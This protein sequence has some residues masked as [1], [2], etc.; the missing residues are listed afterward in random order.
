MMCWNTAFAAMPVAS[1]SCYMSRRITEV[2]A[3]G[4][5]KI[6]G[7]RVKPLTKRSSPLP[8]VARLT[9]CGA[10]CSRLI[11]SVRPLAH[12]RH[13]TNPQSHLRRS[14]RSS[15]CLSSSRTWFGRAVRRSLATMGWCSSFVVRRSKTV[16]RG[17][18]RSSVTF[19]QSHPC[20]SSRRGTRHRALVAIHASRWPGR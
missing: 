20:C 16:D 19:L 10:L 18:A 6:R 15:S 13:E 11:A 3:T 1:C 8:L 7:Q 9:K 4:N 12:A 17:I 5:Q 2:A 14:T